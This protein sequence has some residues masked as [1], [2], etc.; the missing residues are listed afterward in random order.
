MKKTSY[1]V[2]FLLLLCPWLS[3]RRIAPPPNLLFILTE[4][5]G[6]QLGYNGTPGVLTPPMDA[7]AASG[8]Y[9]N[10]AFV[11]YLD[12]KD[13]KPWGNRTYGETVRAKAQFPEAWRILT[14]MDPQSLGGTVPVLEL[15]D[16]K[17]DPAEMLNRVTDPSCHAERDLLYHALRSWAVST[18]DSG[19][20]IPAVPPS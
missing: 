15:Y 10:N 12:S 9:F 7:L 8:I 18:Q 20:A 13:A 19:I 17:S 11:P 4:D 5:Q 3:A 1:I 2:V 14:G 16:L 6:A